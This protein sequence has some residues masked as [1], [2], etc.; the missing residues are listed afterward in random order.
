MTL[1]LCP[2]CESDEGLYHYILKEWSFEPGE[3]RVDYTRC[4]G[5]GDDYGKRYYCDQC[6]WEC[7][8]DNV[9]RLKEDSE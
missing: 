5:E 9:P 4:D 7:N 2:K 8:G 6:G 1:Y 3:W